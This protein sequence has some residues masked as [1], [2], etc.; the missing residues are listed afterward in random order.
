VKFYQE[1]VAHAADDPTGYKTLQRVLGEA[2]MAGF[3]KRWEAWILKLT[4]P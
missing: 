3:Q 4:F 1:F 2:D